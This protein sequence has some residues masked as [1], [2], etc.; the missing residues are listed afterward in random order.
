MRSRAYDLTEIVHLTPYKGAQLPSCFV[1]D[2]SDET[3]EMP[4]LSPMFLP[5]DTPVTCVKCIS[6][7]AQL[8]A[9]DEETDE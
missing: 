9:D 8:R 7:E 2:E 3:K 4:L 6:I 5:S 1:A